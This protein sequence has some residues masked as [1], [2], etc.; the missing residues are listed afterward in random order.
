MTLGPFDVLNLETDDATATDPVAKR[1]DLSGT[2][3]ESD[4]PV[5]V[6][7]GVE[8]AQVPGALKI[9][10][11][12]GWQPG[13]TCCLDHLEAQVPPVD[14]AGTGFVIS[15]S[16]VRAT[17]AFKEADVIRF[18]G[19]TQAAQVTTN[20]PAPFNS[21]S[22][23]PGEVKTTSSQ[24]HV[25]VSSTQPIVVAQLLV[26]NQL[27]DNTKNGDPSLT[28]F[29]SVSQYQSDFLIPTPASWT[30]SY[31]VITQPQGAKVTLD[32][33]APTGCKVE[34]AGMVGGVTYDVH[35]CPLAA[36]ASHRVTSDQPV[37]VVAYGYAPNSSYAFVAGIGL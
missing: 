26:S 8:S 3:V 12:P 28:I 13:D 11:P 5:A 21:F 2:L 19:V 15:R 14:G 6:F 20:L 32:G 7:S 18:V 25:T 17:G 16:P 27:V 36:G 23:Q 33:A 4:K 22:L 30:S 10:T 29:P 31:L 9:A 34:P 35:T 1:S 24:G 37:G